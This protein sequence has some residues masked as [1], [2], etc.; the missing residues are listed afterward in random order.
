MTVSE[1]VAVSQAAAA[2]SQVKTP[3]ILLALTVPSGF[4]FGTVQIV[5][6]SAPMAILN[7]VALVLKTVCLEVSLCV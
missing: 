2:G 6:T 3:K 5:T 1:Q 4:A 7:L